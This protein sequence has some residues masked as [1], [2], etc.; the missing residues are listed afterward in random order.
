MHPDQFLR[1]V[2]N[3]LTEGRIDLDEHSVQIED[4][5]GVVG[6]LKEAAIERFVLAEALLRLRSLGD[7]RIEDVQARVDGFKEIAIHRFS[8]AQARLALPDLLEALL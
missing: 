5:Q 2:A 4:T 1:G 8:L 3:H 7:V 6:R